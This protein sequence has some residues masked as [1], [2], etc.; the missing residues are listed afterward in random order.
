[1][2]NQ[3]V[4]ECESL[5]STDGYITALVRLN[6]CYGKILPV[7]G[8]QGQ[9]AGIVTEGDLRRGILRGEDVQG[10]IEGCVNSDAVVVKEREGEVLELTEDD[11]KVITDRLA[12]N[13]HLRG[14]WELP[15]IDGQGYLRGVVT[16]ADVFP[17]VLS[18]QSA[19]TK[20]LPKS[21]KPNV[22]V[23]G[24]TG[25]IG[26]VLTSELLA[27]GFGVKILDLNLY[28][29]GC[30]PRF[31]ENSRCEYINADVCNLHAQVEAIKDVE[32]VIF[33]AEVV[34]DPSCAYAPERALKTNY[35]AVSSMA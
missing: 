14:M 17:D 31:L 13:P 28:D 27:R 35:L 7:T 25:Y 30:E 15:V 4:R 12:S 2:N 23:V 22:L 20:N 11:I 16:L 3:I 26:S 8:S 24:G 6:G 32:G 5:T 19:D 9:Y 33:L 1:M 18:V 21:Y 29:Q 10:S 34:G